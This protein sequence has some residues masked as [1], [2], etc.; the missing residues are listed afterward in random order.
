MG[1]ANPYLTLLSRAGIRKS[2]AE[3][4][5]ESRTIHELPS[6]R[7]CTYFVP[8]SDFALALKLAKPAA[9]VPINTAKKFLG[10][11]EEEVQALCE[12]ILKTLAKGAMDP[13]E[14][15]PHL[16][17]LVRNLG[18]EGKKRGQTTTLSLGTGRLQAQG[19]IR[20]IA[21]DGRLDGERYKYA[22]WE[23]GP[24]P[25]S[26]N[27][28]ESEDLIAE[29]YWSWIGLASLAHFVWFTGFGKRQAEAIIA[30]AGLVVEPETGLLGTPEAINAFASFKAP[31]EPQVKLLSSLD[32][33]VLLRRDLAAV[34]RPEDLASEVFREKGPSKVSALQDMVAN[35]IFDRGV[36][37]GWWEFDPDA[38]KIVAK[39]WAP[40]TP[41][42][43]KE[44][45]RTEAFI[46]D[47][48]GDCRSF[49]LDSPKSRQPLLAW[50]RGG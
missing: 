11:S 1:G 32:S 49:S 25:S 38:G 3:S 33:L 48:L 14:M 40:P 44:I 28:E 5:V 23:G 26:L 18:D 20:R 8:Q 36:L 45:E 34:L 35:G 43:L 4:A 17:D 16:G 47:E 39:H 24:Q 12:G 27:D 9:E 22:L 41:Q 46:R 50:L 13:R 21:V 2:A 10:V 30:R 31:A 37:I 6:A 7:G 29:R 19:S 15:K 42:T